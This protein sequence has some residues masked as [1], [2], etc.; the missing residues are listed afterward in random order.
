[1]NYYLTFEIAYTQMLHW[2]INNDVVMQ[3][4]WSMKI[5]NYIL[6]NIR[7]W[8]LSCFKTFLFETCPHRPKFLTSRMYD[9][10][11]IL[12]VHLSLTPTSHGGR[13]HTYFIVCEPPMWKECKATHSIAHNIIPFT[14]FLCILS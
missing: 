10:R 2:Y 7:D 11:I 13:A 3:H 9:I 4:C 5:N 1:M 12:C 14:S 8:L 6:F